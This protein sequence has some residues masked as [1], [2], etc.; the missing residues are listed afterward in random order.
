MSKPYNELDKIFPM[1]RMHVRYLVN[2]GMEIKKAFI[3]AD[4]KATQAV[5]NL[6][7][8]KVEVL[9]VPTIPENLKGTYIKAIPL[10]ELKELGGKRWVT[11]PITLK[12]T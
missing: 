7:E 12:M 3:E 6:L 5:L 1:H 2:G 9:K 11:R 4:K 8:S 10:T